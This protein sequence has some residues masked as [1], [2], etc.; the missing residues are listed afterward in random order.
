[1]D[2]SSYPSDITD[3]QWQLIEPH[4][5]PAKAGGR[6]RVAC[7]RTMINGMLYLNRTGC[8]WRMLPRDFGPWSTVHHYYRQFRR[9]GTWEK[10]HDSLREQVR[11]AAGRHATPS[12]GI[13]DSQSIK[14]CAPRK[15][16]RMDTTRGRKSP[17][18]NGI[19]SSTRSA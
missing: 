17:A 13:L 2:A 7:V 8:S 18:E 3:E 12:A 15:G 6:P 16:G 11:V 4:L 9:D 10:L 1:M 14:T 19:W 5:P